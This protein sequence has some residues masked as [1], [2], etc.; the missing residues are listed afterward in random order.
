[1]NQVE[2]IFNSI[3]L[4]IEKLAKTNELD[5]MISFSVIN[6]LLDDAKRMNVSGKPKVDEHINEIRFDLRKIALRIVPAGSDESTKA[7][8]HIK[9]TIEDLRRSL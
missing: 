3:V 6:S 4:M 8:E 7:L 5:D 2:A 9:S 1:M